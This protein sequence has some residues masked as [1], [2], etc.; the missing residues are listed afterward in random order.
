VV[1]ARHPRRYFFGHATATHNFAALE[2][3]SRESGARQV[4]GGGQPVVA[5]PDYDGV[6]RFG[7]SGRH[8]LTSSQEQAGLWLGVH[9]CAATKNRIEIG[10]LLQ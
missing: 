4:S 2:H 3:N 7:R 8:A 1:E 5:G 10:M 6:V 9:Y